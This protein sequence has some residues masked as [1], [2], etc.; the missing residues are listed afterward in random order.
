V[1][2]T[3]IY[4]G[5]AM[6]KLSRTGVA[7][8]TLA[9]AALVAVVMSPVSSV[10]T[11][12]VI[13]QSK[14]F[15]LIDTVL[16]GGVAVSGQAVGDTYFVSSWQTGLYSYDISNPRSPK[17]LDHMGAD[18]IQIQSN[19][20]EDLATNGMIL[21]LSQFNRTDAVNRLLVIDVR[22]PKDMNVIAELPGAGGH[23]LECLYRC[24]WAYASSSGSSS[25]GVIIDLRRPKK[26]KLLKRKW[27]KAI[28]GIAAHDVTEVRPGLVVT[29]ST[30]MF[31]LDVSDPTRPRVIGSTP[32][33]A[34]NTGHNNIW[35]RRGRDRFLI[36]AS[37]G[38]NNGRCEM[39]DEDGKTLQVWDTKKWRIR[40]LRP[41][42]KYTLTNG[43]GHPP[44]DALGVQGCS[45]HWAQAHPRFKD[46]GL[47]AM[48]AYS[49]GVR[50]LD[51]GPYG[52]PREVG[53]FLKD[54]HGAID[55][56]WI[57][58]RI[59]YVVED[60]GGVGA[61]DVVKYTGKL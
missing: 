11:G 29:S 25:A 47:V 14:N 54:V 21:L 49:Q 8:L 7:A 12:D 33:W 34:R 51:I 9:S 36:S 23:T 17:Q 58:D 16:L 45:A 32:P 3:S 22:N 61:F 24:K 18:E 2:E 59:L 31:L 15:R 10:A 30:P 55:V 48:A 35:P 56:E 20:N 27:S 52:K 43:D 13:V 40:G 44:I 1:D 4:Y 5:V 60:G 19:E 38:V 37:E 6:A 53:W 28:R 57:T 41:A 26:P 39:Y 46:G 42:G 50:L